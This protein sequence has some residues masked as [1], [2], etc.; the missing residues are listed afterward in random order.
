MD[1]KSILKFI[2]SKADRP[3]KM[4]ELARALDI[5]QEEYAR[6]RKTVKA[7]L[8]TGELVMLKRSRIGLPEELNVAVGTVQIT[9][10]G[11]GFLIREGKEIDLLIPPHAIGTALD[12]DKVMVRL[13]GQFNGRE[14]GS[15]IKVLERAPRNIVCVFRHAANGFRLFR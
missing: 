6:F 4:K 14:S 9:R 2:A 1:S 15:V 8:E 5:P 13:T 3:L 11:N 7:L 10:S 12:G